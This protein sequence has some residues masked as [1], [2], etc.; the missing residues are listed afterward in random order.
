M[1]ILAS[2]GYNTAEDV[3]NRVRFIINDSEVAGGDV[4]TDTNPFTFSVLN[5]GYE[6]VQKELASVG[7]EVSQVEVWIIG[8]PIMPITDPEG[9]MIID[10][11]GTNI[12][13]PGG[14]GDIFSLTPQLPTDLVLPLKL[15]ERQTGTTDF[16]NPMVQPN[17]GLLDMTPQTFLYDWE[18]KTDGLRFRGATQSQDI[19]LLYRKKLPLLVAPTDPVPIR[20]VT[21][22][23]A[24]YAAAAFVS[25]RGGAVAPAFKQ[26]AVEEIQ[27][28]KMD[29]ARRRQRKQVRRRPYSGRGGQGADRFIV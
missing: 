15:W 3:L 19:K 4:L 20:D 17:T 16:L 6:R 18:W 27:L 28:Y 12:I 1:P 22:A 2:S 23:A 11:T 25:S 21:N 24:Y 13:Y 29:S 8:L 7:L 10:D 5:T 9:R 14:V 26:E